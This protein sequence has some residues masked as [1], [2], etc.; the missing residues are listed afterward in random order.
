MVFVLFYY[1]KN[2]RKQRT[3]LPVEGA[4]AECKDTYKS[5]CA[6]FKQQFTYRFF[7][8][9]GHQAEV[10]DVL[11][12]LWNEDHIATNEQGALSAGDM[13]GI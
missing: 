2:H 8:I 13:K 11:C 9:M 4:A 10:K 12:C 3:N 6:V 5:G 1:Q 7:S